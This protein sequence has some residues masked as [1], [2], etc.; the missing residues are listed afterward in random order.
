MTEK[1]AEATLAQHAAPKFEPSDLIEYGSV[2]DLTQNGP[3]GAID[4]AQYS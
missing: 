2:S 3:S 4:G 1:N